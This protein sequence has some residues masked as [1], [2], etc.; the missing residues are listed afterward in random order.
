MQSNAVE[1]IVA[2]GGGSEEL[3]S[4]LRLI[5]ESAGTGGARYTPRV[6]AALASIVVARAYAK[7][8]LELVHFLYL[9]EAAGGRR[10]YIG[11]LWS[12][13]VARGSA[14]R[15]AIE[16]AASKDRLG[17]EFR[18]DESEIEIRYPDGVFTI[19]YGRMGFLAAL[20][21][22]V[23]TAVGFE[24]VDEV[25]RAHLDATASLT[26]AAETT[27][28]LAQLT[29]EFLRDRLPTGQ[30]RRKFRRL[31]DFLLTTRGPGFT[32]DDADDRAVFDFWARECERGETDSDFRAY[33]TAVEGFI[34]LRRALRAAS[35]RRAMSTS[36]SLGSDRTA[37][38]VD[39]DAVAN[40]LETIEDERGPIERLDEAPLD[41]VKFLNKREMGL[42][43]LFG[44][45]G[46]HAR[47][48]PLSLLR[49]EVFGRHQ[50]R[51]SQALR[52]H[53]SGPEM[54]AL[55][56]GGPDE[57]YASRRKDW[58]AVAAHMNTCRLAALHALA[59]GGRSEA[60]E[61]LVALFPDL[62]M[63]SLGSRVLAGA[64]DNVIALDPS[65]VMRPV[66]AELGDP[67]IA[68]KELLSPATDAR[69]AWR[70]IA[71]QGF[72]EEDLDAP[73]ILAAFAECELVLR[74]L[75]VNLE[76]FLEDL[77]GRPEL[78]GEEDLFAI[79]AKKFTKPFHSLY[80]GKV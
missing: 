27:N 36:R 52:R 28:K 31:V 2:D 6:V 30:S 49:A 8:M 61:G 78:A 41:A 75:Q 19:R 9:A 22:F 59:R 66:L 7:P 16:Q 45:A 71:R 57:D 35:E 24:A 69:R 15:G 25:C 47:A 43:S 76:G 63:P 80:G 51:L 26:A 60:V 65:A 73:E 55:I 12:L 68:G 38:E 58:H 40:A 62:D 11:F 34:R 53:L 70:S 39:P 1:T 54:A 17:P 10:G 5:A 74:R 37:G 21:E 3:T 14:F 48:L 42:M 44:V 32:L 4:A 56:D 67:N 50:S 18:I 23:I 20:L 46:E 13:D 29:Y 33:R 79:D 64:G 72:R 77:D